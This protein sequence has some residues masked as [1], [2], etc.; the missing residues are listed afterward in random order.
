[1]RRFVLFTTLFLIPIATLAQSADDIIAKYVEA[2]GGLA[3]IKTV[4]SERVRGTLMFA[5]GVEGPFV[6]ERERP[7]KM[8]MEVSFRDQTLIRVYDGKSAGWIYNPFA[9]DAAVVPMNENDLKNIQDEADFEGPFINYKAKGNQLE[10]SGTTTVEGKPAYKVKLTNKN[11]DVSYFSFDAAS[12]LLVRWEGKRKTGSEEVPWES[13]FRDYR[14]VNGLEYPFL[15]E[16]SAPGTDQAQ[17]IMADK[18]EVNVT[19]SEAQFKKPNIP[20]AAAPAAP[21]PATTSPGT[22][23]PPSKPN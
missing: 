14:E 23:P 16:S 11:G 2:R 19:I 6:V 21:P 9:A 17:K 15:I 13:Y 10:Y 7:Y 20:A 4:Q 12:F 8:R 18:I 5:P 3:K 22:Q 1:M